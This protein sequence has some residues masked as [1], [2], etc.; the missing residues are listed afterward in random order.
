[1]RLGHQTQEAE[2]EEHAAQAAETIQIQGAAS[3]AQS[4]QAPCA[5]DTDHVD[6]VLA[7]GKRVGVV[8]R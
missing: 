1:M 6:G 4:H 7:Q 2:D 3:D 5:K 8:V